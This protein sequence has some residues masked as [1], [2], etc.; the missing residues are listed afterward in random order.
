MFYTRIAPSLVLH[1][2]LYSK[3]VTFQVLRVPRCYLSQFSEGV[4]FQILED[5]RVP[6][7]ASFEYG[8]GCVPLPETSLLIQELARF[9]A[10][11]WNHSVW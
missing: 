5:I 9:H 2:N 11:F 4:G 7:S 10:E 3:I 6:D 8:E 1:K